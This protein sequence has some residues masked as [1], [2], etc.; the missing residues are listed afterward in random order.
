MSRMQFTVT[1]CH[2]QDEGVWFVQSSDVPGLNAEAATFDDLVQAIT[3]LTPDLIAANLPDSTHDGA[4]TIPV[5][6]QHVVNTRRAD[7]A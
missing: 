5:C 1:V 6:V 3:D 4:S 7:A 2:D